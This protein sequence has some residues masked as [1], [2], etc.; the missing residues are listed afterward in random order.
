MAASETVQRARPNSVFQHR[1]AGVAVRLHTIDD[2]AKR[3]HVTVPTLRKYIRQR[4]IAYAR[5][6][7]KLLFSEQHLE[8]FV[9]ANTTRPGQDVRAGS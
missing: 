9:A 4:R 6:G 2:A 7:G 1:E 5:V 3:L 8:Q